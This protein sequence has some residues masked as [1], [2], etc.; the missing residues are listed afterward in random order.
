MTESHSDS[1]LKSIRDLFEQIRAEQAVVL[2]ERQVLAAAGERGRFWAFI[3]M[4]GAV[5]LGTLLSYALVLEFE[6]H[7]RRGEKE[8][9]QAKQAAESASQFKSTFLAK[10]SHE[11]RTPLTAIMGYADLLVRPSLTKAK[12]QEFV[13]TIRHNGATCWAS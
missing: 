8:L 11:I 9:Q 12:R 10:M 1:A 3:C 6:L 2:R 4:G 13:Q 5:L 7:V